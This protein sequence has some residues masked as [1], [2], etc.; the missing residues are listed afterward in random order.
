MSEELEAEGAAT[1][2]AQARRVEGSR[3]GV[4][5]R[6]SKA[7]LPLR[8]AGHLCLR[9]LLADRM[10]DLFSFSPAYLTAWANPTPYMRGERWG[11]VG[12]DGERWL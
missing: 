3:L 5:R 2:D 10:V 7:R 4:A 6:G 11:E 8:S 9:A 1:Q 12:R